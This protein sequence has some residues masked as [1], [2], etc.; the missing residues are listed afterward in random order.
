MIAWLL[1]LAALAVIAATA[2]SYTGNWRLGLFA[3]F[4]PHLGAAALAVA[5]LALALRVPYCRALALVLLTVAALNFCALRHAMPRARRRI[6]DAAPRLRI[7][8]TNLFLDNK[9]HRRTIDWVRAEK[10]DL[11][12]ACEAYDPWPRELAA[13]SDRYPFA[14]GAALGDIVI[15]SRW[16]SVRTRHALKGWNGNALVLEIESEH[17]PLE[18]IALH[19]MVPWR[20]DP[21]R[22]G[23]NLVAQLT[24]LIE[25][26]AGDLIVVGDF[27]A[28][29]W[30]APMR[31]LVE[32]T[33]LAFGPGSWRG[34]FPDWLPNWMGLPIDLALARGAWQVAS[35]RLG[36]R[37]GSD[38]WPVIFEVVRLKDRESPRLD[39]S[40]PHP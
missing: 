17:G 6:P 4:R 33:G 23:Y 28:T 8:F 12:V 21:G 20:E 32:R 7:A 18:V 1:D 25:G 31:R 24:E 11:F 34:S 22:G 36:P 35:R 30:S 3:H 10:P 13:L 16:P 27:N 26:R 19:T 39:P 40:Q 29:P 38:H 9:Q 15:F 37:L 5:I 14:M 2:A